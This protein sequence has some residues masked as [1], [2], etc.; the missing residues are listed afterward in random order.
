MLLSDFDGV[1]YLPRVGAEDLIEQ[2]RISVRGR[3]GT[4]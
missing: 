2:P 1:A 3:A 4:P